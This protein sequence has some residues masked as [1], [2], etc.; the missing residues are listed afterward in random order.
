M[1]TERALR[2]ILEGIAPVTGDRFFV[3]LAAQLAR[4]LRVKYAFVGKLE[5]GAVP[6]VRSLAFVADDQI[7]PNFEFDLAGTPSEEVVEKSL[8]YFP[9]GVRNKFP[10]DQLLQKMNVESYI[11]VPLFSSEKVPL[12]IISILHDKEMPNPALTQ[13]LVQVFAAGAGAELERQGTEIELTNA[14][15]ITNG[16]FASMLDGLIV[17]DKT[18]VYVDVNPAFCEMTGFSKAELIGATR[19][20]PYWPEE[21]HDK[22]EKAFQKTNSGVFSDTELTFKGKNGERFPVL[23]SPSCVKDDDGNIVRY[24]A[25]IKD[26][27]K[28][29][30]TEIELSE[31]LERF[32]RLSDSSFEGIGITDRGKILD[33]NKKICEMLGYDYSSMIGRDVLTLVAPESRGFV[34]ETIKSGQEKTYE[35]LAIKSDGTLIPVE[36]HGKSIPYKGR[37]VRVTAIRD[38]TERKIAEE[39]L[40]RRDAILQAVG[41]AAEGFLRFTSWKSNIQKILQ[42]L[43]EATNVSR[44]YIFHNHDWENNH[45]ITSMVYEWC[46]PGIEPYI[47][48]PQ[49][50]NFRWNDLGMERFE[51]LHS[52]GQTVFAHVKDLPK[53]E[54][55]TLLA[56]NIKSLVV[57]P[58]IVYENWWGII[59]FDDCIVER[60]WSQ[61]EIDALKA[62]ADTLGAAIYNAESFEKIQQLKQQLEMENEYLRDEARQVMQPGNIVGQSPALKNVLSQ[63]EL[64]ATSDSTVLILGESG[65]GKE[66]VARAIHEGSSRKQHPLIKVNCA[67]IPRELFESEFFGHIKGAFTGA[68]KDRI[69]RFKMADGGTLFLDEVGEIPMALQSKLLRVLQEG[70]FER[71]GEDTTQKVN[72]RIIAATNADLKEAIKH[73]KFRG[74]LF[75]RLSVFPISI[76]PLRERI[77]DVPELAQLFLERI[78]QKLNRPLGKLKKKHIIQLQEYSWPGNVRELE[79]VIER[80][81]L[82]SPPNELIFN[83]PKNLEGARDFMGD[84]LPAEPEG[85][86]VYT[87]TEL[88]D[89]ERKNLL[90]ALNKSNW[91]I[92]G[93]GGVAELLSAHPNTITSRIKSLGI[94]RPARTK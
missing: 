81:V 12:G 13:D 10:H 32:R 26:I 88:K 69:G 1:S 64:V 36:V 42:R 23:V 71:V 8:C 20:F 72:V 27:T 7:L 80:A 89:F 86:E 6:K 53:K 91:K 9:E 62:A 19:P 31:S 37:T 84:T 44:S 54:Q 52:E 15:E 39:S 74:D 48:D 14:L 66:L 68:I 56:Q 78:C 33:V 2:S 73:N 93:K 87:E 28:L 50:K 94:V 35:H 16:L 25:T 49:L 46:A 17:L 77:E 83:L 65:T 22:I 3:Q 40:R 55:D 24:F 29:K 30:L 43:G 75:Y 60:D 21:E 5:E 79:N 38:L 11:G 47:N 85:A 34:L 82:V 90:K 58:I 59:G 67:S 76:A 61:A 4:T 41:F 51:L 63:I 92:A 18:G 70:E 57:V 45:P